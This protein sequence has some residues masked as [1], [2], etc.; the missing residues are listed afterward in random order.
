MS[1]PAAKLVKIALLVLVLGGL[2]LFALHKHAQ[3]D[4]VRDSPVVLTPDCVEKLNR[5]GLAV[6]TQY[7]SP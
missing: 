4:E 2:Y 5:Y 3:R 7:Q 1:R 6:G